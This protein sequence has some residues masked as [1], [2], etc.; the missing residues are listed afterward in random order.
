[1]PEIPVEQALC[2]SD[3]TDACRLLA[4]SPGFLDEWQPE[5]Q[6]LCS[7]FGSRPAG[8]TCSSSVFAQPFGKKHVAVVHAADGNQPG[9]MLFHLLIVPRAEYESSI[10]DPFVLADRFPPAWQ[11]RGDLPPLAWPAEPLPRRT[12]AEV[13][14]ILKSP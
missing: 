14:R 4:R 13:Q 3:G 5:A 11:A 6:R 8:V 7:G 9:T 1:M 2:S 10:G 12:V